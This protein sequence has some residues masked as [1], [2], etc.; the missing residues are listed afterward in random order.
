[1]EQKVFTIYCL[2]NEYFGLFVRLW[3]YV[4]LEKFHSY[5]DVTITDGGLQI[6][7]YTRHSWSLSSEDSLAWLTSVTRVFRLQWSS[8]RTRDTRAYCRAFGSGAVTTCFNDFGQ[9]RPGIKTRTLACKANANKWISDKISDKSIYLSDKW[10][11]NYANRVTIIKRI[12]MWL[13]RPLCFG[14]T[15]V[16]IISLC[17]SFTYMYNLPL[18]SGNRSVHFLFWHK[19]TRAN[20]GCTSYPIRQMGWHLL[21]SSNSSVQ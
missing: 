21:P 5:G 17:L 14:W 13:L 3:F 4:P 6:L 10:W 18:Q 9:S 8:P 20:P 19:I 12:L 16:V 11:L 2:I 7:T 15:R 1:M